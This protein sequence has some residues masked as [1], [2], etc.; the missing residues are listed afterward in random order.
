LRE[1]LGGVV[2]QSTFTSLPE[3]GTELFPWLPVRLIST[4][5]YDTRAKLP[6]IRVP[7]L[8]MHSRTDELARFHH[9]EENFA[10]ANEPKFFCEL[11]GAHNEAVW[12]Q[13][14]FGE[15]IGRLLLAVES[16]ARP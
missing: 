2:L 6:R 7:V 15:A 9:G 1:A 8:V 4:I 12:T 13:P 5:K 16:R 11:N 14:A 3:I 10:V